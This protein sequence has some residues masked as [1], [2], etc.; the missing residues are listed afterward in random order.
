MPLPRLSREVKP[1]APLPAP[2]MITLSNGPRFPE[3]KRPPTVPEA[4]AQR[5]TDRPCRV[6][7]SRQAKGDPTPWQRTSWR[8]LASMGGRAAAHDRDATALA[9]E[10]CE[11]CCGPPPWIVTA[12]SKGI[13]TG[14]RADLLVD[15]SPDGTVRARTLWSADGPF[16]D[17]AARDNGGPPAVLPGSGWLYST[18]TRSNRVT[19]YMR[20]GAKGTVVCGGAMDGCASSC[21]GDDSRTMTF[22]EPKTLRPAIQIS[23]VDERIAVGPDGVVDKPEKDPGEPYLWFSTDGE[24]VLVHGESC[25][26]PRVPWP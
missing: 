24:G 16:S 3:C 7:V 19:A 12:S 23:Y 11:D 4:M 8:R 14:F 25:E 6:Q 21:L 22:F 5:A 10:L 26:G 15:E 1:D 20:E 17:C 9:R 13:G 2:D 18:L